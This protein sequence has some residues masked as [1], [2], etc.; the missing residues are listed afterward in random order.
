MSSPY[1]YLKKTNKQTKIQKTTPTSNTRLSDT[2]LEPFALK[3]T[4]RQAS[5]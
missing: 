3:A 5:L 1:K 2:I 4:V